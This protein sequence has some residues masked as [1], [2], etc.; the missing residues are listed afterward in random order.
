MGLKEEVVS[1]LGQGEWYITGDKESSSA[2]V[3]VSGS[4]L[5]YS[6]Y[7]DE[8][9]PLFINGVEEQELRRKDDGSIVVV[10]SVCG[11]TETSM[12]LPADPSTNCKKY[13][14]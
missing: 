6:S 10:Y 5:S 12:V 13:T 3:I 4:S 14:E 2:L 9:G 11:R 7:Q 8:R 1:T